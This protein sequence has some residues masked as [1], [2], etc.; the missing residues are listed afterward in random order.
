MPSSRMLDTSLLRTGDVLLSRSTDK[1]S[2]WIAG[3]TGGRFSHASIYFKDYQIFEA[4]TDGVGFSE[5]EPVRVE[6][7][8]NRYRVLCSASKFEDIALYRCPDNL[9]TAPGND[10][11]KLLLALQASFYSANGSE[12]SRG[13]GF[14]NVVRL[15]RWVPDVVKQRLLK[16]AGD[17]VLGDRRKIL[18]EEYFCSE[19]IVSILPRLGLPVLK[20]PT[21][22]PDEISPNNLADSKLSLLTEVSNFICNPDTSAELAPEYV[23]MTQKMTAKAMSQKKIVKMTKE[24]TKITDDMNALTAKRMKER[25]KKIGKRK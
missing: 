9:R 18:V 13:K 1:I 17:T 21:L 25:M 3:L 6:M 12:Y 20:D 4:V 11:F 24:F 10:D 23:L 19:L 2:P 7:Q 16:I 22:C 8:N 15:P 5:L 14:E